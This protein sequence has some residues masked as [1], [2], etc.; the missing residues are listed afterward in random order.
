MRAGVSYVGVRLTGTPSGFLVL[1]F[2]ADVTTGF[3]LLQSRLRVVCSSVSLNLQSTRLFSYCAVGI[4]F[5]VVHGVLA[6]MGIVC[7]LLHLSRWH[8]SSLRSDDA[9]LA[10]N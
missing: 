5:R 8:S 1:R 10:C 7:S 9:H 3:C 4:R 6:S 2:A